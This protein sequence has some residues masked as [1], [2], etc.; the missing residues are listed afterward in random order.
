MGDKRA[1]GTSFLATEQSPDGA[2]ARDL[3][4]DAERP[5]FRVEGM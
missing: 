5:E 4:R 1:S 3:A 2:T